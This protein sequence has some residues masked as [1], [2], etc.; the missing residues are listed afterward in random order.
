MKLMILSKCQKLGT[1]VN[2]FS[3]LVTAVSGFSK[4]GSNYNIDNILRGQIGDDAYFIARHVD[5]W[6]RSDFD[7]SSTWP[8]QNNVAEETNATREKVR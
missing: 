7:V 6:S 3:Y 1:P 2:L 8:G 5:E 4:P